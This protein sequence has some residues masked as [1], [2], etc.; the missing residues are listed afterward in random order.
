V[1]VVVGNCVDVVV[2]S[3]VLVVVGNPVEVVVG[4]TVLVVVSNSVEVVVGSAVVVVGNSVELVVVPSL[5]IPDNTVNSELFP[6][7]KRFKLT[8]IAT[9]RN[10]IVV[11]YSR[12]IGRIRF[13]KM[14]MYAH[15]SSH[16]LFVIPVLKHL[17]IHFRCAKMVSIAKSLLFICFYQFV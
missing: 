17:T 12:T 16:Y 1:L 5:A 9:R 11:N 15:N 13:T 10:F 3:A 7:N 6:G 8:T 2:G 14:S 4:S